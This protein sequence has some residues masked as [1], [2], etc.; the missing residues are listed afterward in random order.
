M[1]LMR[2]EA[3]A[4]ETNSERE[5]EWERER[6]REQI[7]LE[8]SLKSRHPVRLLLGRPESRAAMI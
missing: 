6:E 1:S 4:R 7:S 5:S 2:V 8:V 3:R